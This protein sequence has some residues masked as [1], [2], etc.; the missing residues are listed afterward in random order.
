MTQ[1]VLGLIIGF[2]LASYLWNA[3]VKVWVNKTVF[4]KQPKV[5]ETKKEETKP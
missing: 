5:D 3:K 2:A 4:K 1:F